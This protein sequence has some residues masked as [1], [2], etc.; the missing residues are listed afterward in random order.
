MGSSFDFSKASPIPSRARVAASVLPS[1]AVR[2]RID[3]ID[4]LRGAV[5]ILMALDHT[6]DFFSVGG[7]DPRNVTDPALFLTRWIT[8][9]CAPLFIFIAGI[10]AYLYGAQKRT[11]GEVS[12]FLLT[13]GLW[14]IV[15]E[16]TVVRLAWSFSLDLNLFVAQ[17][18]WAIGAAMV[19][20]GGLVYLPR[21]VIA[22]VGLVMIGG[23]NLLDGVRAEDLGA[24]GW[25]WNV[26]HQRGLLQLGPATALYVLYPLVP[27]I[28]VMAT[29][30]A[31]GPV[32]EL[33]RTARLRRL[34]ALGVLASVG[35]I[36]L[37]ASN[38]YGDPAS[39]A[40]QVSW[41]ATLLSFIDCEKYPPSLLY[42]AMTLGPGLL[43]LAAFEGARGAFARLIITFGRVPFFY[44]V[45][46]IFLIHALAV[47]LAWL[48]WGD[49][50]WLFGLHGPPAKPADYG[51]SLPGVY[52]VWL[53][54][55][56]ALYPLCRWF[57]G[58]KQRRTEWWWSYL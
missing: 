49:A 1:V 4:L 44:Y 58:L 21:W 5:M 2:P 26:L 27:W 50:S 47:A 23:H 39:W 36:V 57:A 37:R 56:S 52:L 25:L 38:L 48:V 9:F 10:S 35:F 13:R 42:L 18:I 32:F 15:I 30:Y 43:L 51:L 11:V 16:F 31:L 22:A 54:V 19:V 8:H 40:S 20:L 3:S 45:V 55:V 17:V 7:L 46:H 33:D 53:L 14:L 6:R 34:V 29:G 12:R 24:A 41:V 28:G